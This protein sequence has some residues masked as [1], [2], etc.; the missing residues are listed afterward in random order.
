[1]FKEKKDSPKTNNPTFV[2]YTKHALQY[3]EKRYGGLGGE[4]LARTDNAIIQEL[5]GRTNTSL[6]LDVP[7]GTG[8]V[9][10]Y[11]QNSS[12]KIIG[13]DLTEA[14]LKMAQRQK[15]TNVIGLTR[16][17]ADQLPFECEFFELLVSLSFFHLFPSRCRK[18]FAIEFSRVLKPGGYLLCSFTNGWYGGGINWLRRAVG[19]KMGNCSVYFLM[20]GEIQNLFPGWKTIALRGNF[21]P[22]QRLVTYL[23]YAPEKCLRW[24][25]NYS[26]VRR[27]CFTQF[28]LLKKPE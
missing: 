4:F 26:P 25:T 1:M 8:R 15:M 20:P 17:K 9:S 5:V 21:L 14:M 13:C 11:L 16:C 24:L 28:Y 7:T 3:D 19:H 22:L 6:C 10:R 12:L 2:D 23:G 18:E 27:L